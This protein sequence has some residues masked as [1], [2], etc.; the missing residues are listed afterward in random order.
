MGSQTTYTVMPETYVRHYKRGAFTARP[1]E[2]VT[3]VVTPESNTGRFLDRMDQDRQSRPCSRTI[4]MRGKVQGECSRYVIQNRVHYLSETCL[5]ILVEGLQTCNGVLTNQTYEKIVN[6]THTNRAFR[7]AEEIKR[8]KEEAES[9]SKGDKIPE[10]SLDQELDP[11]EVQEDLSGEPVTVAL[12]HHQQ[13]R[14]PRLLFVTKVQ[15]DTEGQSLEGRTQDL[16]ASGLKLLFGEHVELSPDQPVQIAFHDLAERAGAEP[17]EFQSISYRVCACGTE[18]APNTS[19]CL[20][21][22]DYAGA[23]QVKKLLATFVDKNERKYKLDI[24][25]LYAEAS[26]TLYDTLYALNTPQV[27]IFIARSDH[28]AYRAAA[29][30]RTFGNLPL[31]KFFQGNDGK[32][33]FG[34]LCIPERLEALMERGQ[35]L[36]ALCRETVDGSEQILSR[37]EIDHTEGDFWQFSRHASTREHHRFCMMSVREIPVVDNLRPLTATTLDRLTEQLKAL[38]AIVMVHD[39]S[40]LVQLALGQTGSSSRASGDHS[41]H[42]CWIGMTKGTLGQEC[43]PHDGDDQQSLE[44]DNIHFDYVERRSEDRYRAR[45]SVSVSLAKTEHQGVTRDISIMGLCVELEAPGDVKVGDVVSIHFQALQKQRRRLNL[46]SVPY[47]IMSTEN[48]D[49]TVLRLMRR[50]FDRNAGDIRA[51]LQDMIEFNRGKFPVDA[52]DVRN[53]ALA[54]RYSDI[55]AENLQS[56]PVFLSRDD[57]YLLQVS[58][59]GIPDSSCKLARHFEDQHGRIRL[60]FLNDPVVRQ[61]LHEWLAHCTGEQAAS[62]Q[63]EGSVEIYVYRTQQ[64]DGA[65]SQLHCATSLQL[66]TPAQRKAYIREAIQ[67]EDHCF[68]KLIVAPRSSAPLV[69]ME[70]V[71][72]QLRGHR[73]HRA[74]QLSK[75]ID[76]IVAVGEI[77]DL[78]EIIKDIYG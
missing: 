57:D 17:E 71:L 41:S 32:Y 39:V 73:K 69:A 52:I 75:D 53:A 66:Q 35:T 23:A 47:K 37:A 40:D 27:P 61:R 19:V 28:G 59:V 64:P 54:C 34:P 48:Q 68:V 13:R 3:E 16:S 42:G 4:D 65:R 46:K 49:G 30:G 58:A 12:G 9:K 2:L 60:A 6:G 78:T 10:T 70:P 7:K 18:T 31:A 29:I 22:L 36:V 74:A 55:L 14:E 24:E 77:L 8:S 51:F 67:H 50:V 45:T 72:S 33:D 76:G 56:L 38:S 62:H 11:S 26:A 63:N 1:K 21:I 44:P 15:M 20:E 25:D 5:A 43:P